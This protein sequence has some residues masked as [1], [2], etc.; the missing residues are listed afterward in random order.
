MNTSAIT[1]IAIS[2]SKLTPQDRAIAVELA[3]GLIGR[4]E[5]GPAEAKQP[6]NGNDH[7]AASHLLRL[8]QFLKESP[9]MTRKERRQSQ[10]ELAQDLG[11]SEVAIKNML[12]KIRL[13]QK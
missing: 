4:A 7:W 2:L 12:S 11:R 13:G 8:R 5:A 10:S 3:K 9:A 6:E 1:A